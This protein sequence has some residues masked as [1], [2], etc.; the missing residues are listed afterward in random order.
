MAV[1]EGKSWAQTPDGDDVL[2]FVYESVITPDAPV[3][4]VYRK[5]GDTWYDQ[6]GEVLPTEDSTELEI[7]TGAHD[8]SPLATPPSE[9]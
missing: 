3:L 5:S 8:I 1:L 9:D 7:T 4:A 6:N 2:V